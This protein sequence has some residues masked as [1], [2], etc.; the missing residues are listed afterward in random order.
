M[1]AAHVQ[2]GAVKD[3]HALSEASEEQ[4]MT[5]NFPFPSLP[6]LSLCLGGLFLGC[7]VPGGVLTCDSSSSLCGP[8]RSCSVLLV[9]RM[10][11]LW[12]FLFCLAW[13]A[14]ALLAVSTGIAPGHAGF[15]P[16]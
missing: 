5:P 11:K 12:D 13:R 1:R 15:T 14:A 3:W 7:G 6:S 16:T 10:D 4:L 9:L 2:S 8:E